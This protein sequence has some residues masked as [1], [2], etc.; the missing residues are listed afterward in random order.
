MSPR[1]QVRRPKAHEQVWHTGILYLREHTI[2]ANLYW[3]P[4][5]EHSPVLRTLQ[6]GETLEFV[7]EVKFSHW[8]VVRLEHQLGWVTLQSVEIIEDVIPEP[9]V[10]PAQFLLDEPPHTARY[11]DVEETMAAR[12]PEFDQRIQANIETEETMAARPPHL[13]R[14]MRDN[15]EADDTPQANNVS[16]GDLRRLIR[17]V[18]GKLTGSHIRD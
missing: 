1:K 2:R 11:H 17:F 18:T 13:D 14:R 6:G 10:D 9:A 8:V 16:T 15:M 4:D 12:P 5:P 3:T 7:P